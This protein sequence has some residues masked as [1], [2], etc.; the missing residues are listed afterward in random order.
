MQ[1]AKKKRTRHSKFTRER[2][3]TIVPH[4]MQT[5]YFLYFCY[6][7]RYHKCPIGLAINAFAIRKTLAKPKRRPICMRLK[8]RPV[9]RHIRWAAHPAVLVHTQIMSPMALII[10]S[11][12]KQIILLLCISEYDVNL[13]FSLLLLFLFLCTRYIA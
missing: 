9:P 3:K 10:P 12:T 6:F 4:S 11:I 5:V 2:T 13:F 1:E 8:R 7:S